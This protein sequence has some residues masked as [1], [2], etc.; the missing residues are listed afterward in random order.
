[1]TRNGPIHGKRSLLICPILDDES[2][3][4]FLVG[5][6]HYAQIVISFLPGL[7]GTEVISGKLV[8]LS[9]TMPVS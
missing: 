5:M 6:L 9:Q 4:V 3:I 8:Y 7:T 1:M 2:K